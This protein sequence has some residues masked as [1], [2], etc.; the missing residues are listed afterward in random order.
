MKAFKLDDL[1]KADA[2]IYNDK[3]LSWRKQII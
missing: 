3:F 2:K 1:G